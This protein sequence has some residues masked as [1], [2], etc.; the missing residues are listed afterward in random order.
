MNKL[1]VLLLLVPTMSFGQKMAISEQAGTCLYLSL[2][3]I[4]KQVTGF[5]NQLAVSYST[6]KHLSVSVLYEY[7]RWTASANGVGISPNFVSK[8]FFAGVDLKVVQVKSVIRY[9]GVI[10]KYSPS[11]GYGLHAGSKQKLIGHLYLM[12]QLGW[13]SY[14]LQYRNTVNYPGYKPLYSTT[15]HTKNFSYSYLRVGLCFQF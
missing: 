11:F 3:N 14:K 10:Y 7:D 4:N 5:S 2:D 15:P 13:D 1:M 6:L 12:E 9:D 8:Y